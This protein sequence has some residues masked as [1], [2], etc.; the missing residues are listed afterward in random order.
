MAKHPVWILCFDGI[1]PL[2]VVGPHEVFAG[3]GT[4]LAGRGVAGAGYDVR[5]V[6]ATPGP[7][8]SESGLALVAPDALP[9]DPSGTVVVPGGAGARHSVG[10]DALVGWVR[11][12]AA[13]ADRIAS[14]CTGS[15]LLAAAGVLDG[16][17]A[18]THWARAQQLAD[19][20]P[21]VDVQVDPLYVRQGKVWTSA[22]VTAGIDLAL[23]IVE[24]DHGAEVAHIAARWLV[25]FVRRPGGQSQFAGPVWTAPA[26][27][28]PVRA[29]Q[30]LIDAAPEADHRIPALASRVGMS[31]RHLSRE[32]TRLVGISPGRYVEQVRVEHARRLLETEPVTVAAAASRCGFGSAETMRL[33]FLRRVGAPPDHY[34]RRFATSD[35][36]T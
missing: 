12:A 33:A 31:P 14:V 11:Q 21:A 24:E 13:S 27:P 4:I 35:V 34:R 20:F 32:F 15:F 26:P 17:S 1:Q 19:D 9:L 10:D 2:D 7:I 5:L 29:A 25:M 16:L 18:T 28:G 23:A 8:R 22:G 6:A 3:V 36:L 30:E